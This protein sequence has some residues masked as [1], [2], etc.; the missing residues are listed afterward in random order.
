MSKERYPIT[1]ILLMLAMGGLTAFGPTASAQPTPSAVIRIDLVATQGLP[2]LDTGIYLQSGQPLMIRASGMGGYG[3]ESAY[4][5]GSCEGHPRTNP[6]GTRYLNGRE[7]YPPTKLDSNAVEPWQPVG[8]L[9]ARI[10][11]GHWFPVGAQYGPFYDGSG[12]LYLLY[13]ESYWGDNT[14]GY[15]VMIDVV[16]TDGTFIKV[17]FQPGI[18]RIENGRKRAFPDWDTYLSHG[19]K[20]D[21]SNII[22]ISETEMRAIPNGPDFQ[23]VRR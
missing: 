17:H 15:N 18:Y 19:G 2:G 22:H 4:P 9:L 6:W 13:N 3:Y 10:G 5:G 11:D 1:A 16:L 23:S 7:C 8:M 21:Y 20:F 12:R 14:G